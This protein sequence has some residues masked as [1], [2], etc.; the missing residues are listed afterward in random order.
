MTRRERP[1]RDPSLHTPRKTK[2]THRI[3]DH[4]SAPPQA[5]RQLLLR[6][7]EVQQQLLV[8]GRLLEWVQVLTVHVL[9]ERIP[10]HLIV[11]SGTDDRRDPL[12]PRRSSRS[13]SS[14]PHDDLI[15]LAAGTNHDRLQDTDRFNA[16]GQLLQRLLIEGPTRLTRIGLD[17]IERQLLERRP[18]RCLGPL[19]HL[20]LLTGC[21][22][23]G[24]AVFLRAARDQGVQPTAKATTAS[25]QLAPSPVRVSKPLR[26][27][28]SK[29]RS[30]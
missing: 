9:E 30:R 14:L 15:A 19:L 8:G 22:R 28:S 25:H 17:P 29:V 2:K 7:P 1:G 11:L 23:C 21:L 12:Q 26:S 6:D 10:E 5:R 20:R 27:A 24:V 13:R 4:G 16:H 3:R 18:G